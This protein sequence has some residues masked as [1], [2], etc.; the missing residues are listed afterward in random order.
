MTST[1]I[2]LT[3]KQQVAIH[4]EDVPARPDGRLL[5]RTQASLVST[6]TQSICYRGEMD[7]DHHWHNWVQYPLCLSYRCSKG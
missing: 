6:G 4:T 3:G 7:N 2:V 5:A 1:N